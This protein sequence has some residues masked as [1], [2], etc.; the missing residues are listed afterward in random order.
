MFST[1]KSSISLGIKLI[2]LQYSH[3]TSC[4]PPLL[5]V[6][7][8]LNGNTILLRQTVRHCDGILTYGSKGG[9]CAWDID[10]DISSATAALM[11][12]SAFKD[13][14]GR[15]IFRCAIHT[16][17]VSY[18]SIRYFSW[19]GS[20]KNKYGWS[21]N[22]L[23][24]FLP[25]A[26]TVE[27]SPR[28]TRHRA[29]NIEHN[30]AHVPLFTLLS[31]KRYIFLTGQHPST[32]SPTALQRLRRCAGYVLYSISAPSAQHKT[33]RK[34]G[35][36]QRSTAESFDSRDKRPEPQNSHKRLFFHSPKKQWKSGTGRS[37][38][39]FTKRDALQE[40]SLC[41][42]VVCPGPTPSNISLLQAQSNPTFLFR[43]DSSTKG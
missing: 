36:C 12:D 34:E 31:M 14:S 24:R 37:T 22:I 1:S 29:G 16:A 9:I 17:L 32:R 38:N 19:R 28:K 8:S 25:A 40:S 10:N 30:S 42:N 2:C 21:F 43:K 15:Y 5:P 4:F 7:L 39:K 6:G 18:A 13:G 3:G 23:W 26:Q 20:N 35:R 41:R 11:S 33:Y 27:T